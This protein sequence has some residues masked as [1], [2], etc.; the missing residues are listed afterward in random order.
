[1][2]NISHFIFWCEF[3]LLFY[4]AECSCT[5]NS[6]YVLMRSPACVT[7]C[8]WSGCFPSWPHTWY[9]SQ[10]GKGQDLFPRFITDRCPFRWQL[11]HDDFVIGFPGILIAD[12]AFGL[13]FNSFSSS[14]LWTSKTERVSLSSFNRATSC[15][16][17][18]SG[19]RGAASAFDRGCLSGVMLAGVVSTC[20]P[21]GL[22]NLKRFGVLGC[23]QKSSIHC[24]FNLDFESGVCN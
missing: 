23:A 2:P 15:S 21:T 3:G 17:K 14:F 1:M 24:C 11:S 12:S 10:A 5:C 4:N 16:R 7:D 22:P 13:R 9:P 6:V 20:R 8:L 19:A 18:F